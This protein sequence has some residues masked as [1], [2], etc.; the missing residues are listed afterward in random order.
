MA[1]LTVAGTEQDLAFTAIVAFRAALAGDRVLLD[2]FPARYSRVYLQQSIVGVTLALV[3]DPHPALAAIRA[4]RAWRELTDQPTTFSA[5]YEEFFLGT[6]THLPSGPPALTHSQWIEFV[7]VSLTVVKSVA[8]EL[9]STP[10]KMLDN[11]QASIYRR[12]S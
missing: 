2:L 7:E 9:F 12:L 5:C 1:K 11:L 8:E 3:D 6:R 10:E 4:D